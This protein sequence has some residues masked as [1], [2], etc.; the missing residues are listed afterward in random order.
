MNIHD[1]I[2][3]KYP[4]LI[5]EDQYISLSCGKGWHNIILEVCDKIK[6]H[7]AKIQQIKEKFGSLRIY[8]DFYT[9]GRIA[10]DSIIG[11]KNGNDVDYKEPGAKILIR[12]FDNKEWNNV[13]GAIRYYY[14]PKADKFLNLQRTETCVFNEE[15][16]KRRLAHLTGL[17]DAD[18]ID[19]EPMGSVI[20][21]AEAE[22]MKICE[23][24]GTKEGVTTE[25]SW[26]KTLCPACRAK[27]NWRDD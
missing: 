25:G 17:V 24:C 3:E 26:I 9:D 6:Y 12:F 5:D 7:G 27:K 8:T 21:W 20:A 2:K 13:D 15:F 4:H 10:L 1:Q 14:D 18:P 11:V 16:I 22:S 19:E 23:S